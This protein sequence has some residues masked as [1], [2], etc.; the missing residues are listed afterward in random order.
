M[1]GFDNDI[2]Y[3]NGV[4]LEPSSAQDIALMQAT[5]ND[6]SRVNGTGSPESVVAANPSSIY[7]DRTSGNFWLKQTGTGNTGWV[8]MSA[9]GAYTSLAPFIVGS[10]FADYPTIQAALTA[11]AALVP[12]AANPLNIY[13]KPKGSPYVEDL[14]IPPFVKINGFD[15]LVGADTSFVGNNSVSIQGSHTTPAA[16]GDLF[17]LNNIELLGDGDT[18]FTTPG[19]TADVLGLLTNCKYRT[20]GA[21]CKFAT[22]VAGSFLILQHSNCSMRD[23]AFGS[24]LFTSADIPATSSLYYYFQNSF[25]QTYGTNTLDGVTDG[26]VSIFGAHNYMETSDTVT[27]GANYS[28]DLEYTHRIANSS[29]DTNNSFVYRFCE[30][31]SGTITAASNLFGTNSIIIFTSVAGVTPEFRNCTRTSNWHLSTTTAIPLTTGY[32]SDLVLTNSNLTIT[33]VA[34]P[35]D[36]QTQIIKDKQGTATATPITVSANGNTI[37]GAASYSID[38]NYGWVEVCY[39]AGT[40]NW[41]IIGKG[42][43]GSGGVNNVVGGP[44]VT[45]T[46]SGTTYTVNSVVYTNQAGSTS[47]TK[48]SGSFSTAAVTLTTPVTAGLVDGDLLEFV[49]T[50]GVLIIQLAATQVAHL[51]SVAT[52]AAGSLT[53][54]ATGD[55]ISMR[56]QASTNDWW[57]TSSIGT[58]LLA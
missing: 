55:S 32:F 20:T 52:T 5:A 30:V 7:H 45:V 2:G 11:A 6:V 28:E 10:S 57:V 58:W 35:F 25:V 18:F 15:P 51:G 22:I 49:A 37:D 46:N 29:F 26:D 17:Y 42:I 54:A 21:A 19:G 40:T 31:N 13:V 8:Q 48:N 9:G 27:N 38:Q 41:E 12:T 1:A 3:M 14:V 24:T 43:G 23:G 44:G 39:T 16:S 36:G 4:R 33:L 47:V 56:Y 50:S 53:S 34:L